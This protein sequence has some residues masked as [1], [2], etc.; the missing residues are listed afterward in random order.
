MPSASAAEGDQ[1][2]V[3]AMLQFFEVLAGLCMSSIQSRT[4]IGLLNPPDATDVVYG[5][6]FNVD[7]SIMIVL[8]R[9]VR[10][11][12]ESVPSLNDNINYRALISTADTLAY[13]TLIQG[14]ASINCENP[15]ITDRDTEMAYLSA[16]VNSLPPMYESFDEDDV[17]LEI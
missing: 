16:D 7:A 3:D 15:I 11:F 12:G 1:D 6:P 4:G 14:A 8:P 10:A 17:M 2:V 13:A 9:V 5:P